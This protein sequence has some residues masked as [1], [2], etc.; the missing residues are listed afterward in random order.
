MDVVKTISG[1]MYV[2]MFQIRL[3]SNINRMEEFDE[4]SPDLGNEV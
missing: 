4:K 2:C 1:A 3:L